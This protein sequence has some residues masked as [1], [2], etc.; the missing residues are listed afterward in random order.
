M[1]RNPKGSQG[2]DIFQLTFWKFD[3]QA[4]QENRAPLPNPWGGG[5]AA[6]G[7]ASRASTGAGGGAAPTGGSTASPMAGMFQSPGMQSLMQQV[8][9][10]KFSFFFPKKKSFFLEFFDSR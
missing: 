2:S 5:S 3:G 8:H 9:S 1:G 7:A 4:G 6:D 10:P